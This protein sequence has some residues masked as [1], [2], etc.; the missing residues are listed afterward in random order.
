[1]KFNIQNI[2]KAYCELQAHT[3]KLKVLAGLLNNP[4][5]DFVV[6]EIIKLDPEYKEHLRTVLEIMTINAYKEKVH[7]VLATAINFLIENNINKLTYY[8]KE[9]DD[10]I[11]M[12]GTSGIELR[13]ATVG[14]LNPDIIRN[15]MKI[16]ESEILYINHMNSKLLTVVPTVVPEFSGSKHDVTTFLLELISVIKEFKLEDDDL[17]N[18]TGELN[19]LL[20]Y[21]LS[22]DIEYTGIEFEKGEFFKLDITDLTKAILEQQSITRTDLN[23]S[24]AYSNLL[25]ALMSKLSSIHTIDSILE[26]LP[27]ELANTNWVTEVTVR[28][29]E[30]VKLFNNNEITPTDY[31][32]F[33]NGVLGSVAQEQLYLYGKLLMNML[34]TLISHI[35]Y[36]MLLDR[37]VEFVNETFSMVTIKQY[38]DT[39][40][41]AG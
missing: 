32:N 30:Q 34:P 12:L 39:A 15:T 5:T 10:S 9:L 18:V 27:A 6:K 8:K 1:M 20:E 26:R 41:D 36:I 16:I 2:T 37:T 28:T 22:E 33:V 4:D 17:D 35:E 38:K 11:A 40:A 25:E 3:N 24:V 7:G 23:P 31:N 14:K 29:Q 19:K 13:K 21:S